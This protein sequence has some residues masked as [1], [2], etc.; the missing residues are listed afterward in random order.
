MGE[1]ANCLTPP[2]KP[3][4]PL[5]PRTPMASRLQSPTSFPLGSND[6]QLERAQAR[7]ARAASI[8][9]KP[10]S[11]AAVATAQE[12][13]P[14]SSDLL[15]HDQIMDLFH[16]CIKLASENK[17]NQKN[18]WDLGLIDHLSEIV[19]ARPE[20]DDETNFQKASCT[21]EAGVKIYSMRVD[22]VHSEAYKVLGGINRAGR[23][24][25]KET[26]E[27]CNHVDTAQGEGL[28]K[29]DLER[30]MSPVSTLESS[31]DALNVKKFDV[32]FTVDPLYHQTSAQ[33][34]EGGAKG[35][36]LNNLG[37]YG[38]CRVLFDSLEAPDKSILTEAQLDKS[39]L[40][41]LSFVKE[42]IESMMIHMPVICDISPTL[43]D[44]LDQ[45]DEENRRPSD[46][47]FPGQMPVIE[48]NEIGDNQTG[49]DGNSLPDC[50][51]CNFDNDDHESVVDDM[52]SVMDPY[53]TSYQEASGDYMFEDPGIEEKSEKIA[54]FLS[55]GLG[56]SSKTNAWA[57]PDHWKYRKVKGLEPTPVSPGE[58]EIAAKKPKS[59]K[60]APDIDFTKSLDNEMPDIFAPPKNPKSLL[61]P[62]NRG[63]CNITLPEDCHYRPESLVKLFVL[64]DVM[65]LRRKGTKSS[66]ESR[67]DNTDFLPS[68]SWD[69]ESM[70]N[71]QLDDA[72]I[73]SDVEDPGSLLRKPRQ[74]NKIDI[75]YD[76]VSKQVDV[77]ALKDTLWNHIQESIQNSEVERR[78]ATVSLTH[79]MH[80]LPNNCP[81]ASAKDISPHLLFICLLHLANEH[82]LA[83]HDCPTLDE[84]DIHIPPSALA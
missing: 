47:A 30:K 51:P 61:L 29:K 41:D 59:R 63:P 53:P 54:D 75:Q 69:N 22:S 1:V 39:D 56:F 68:S 19:R 36:L 14:P 7:A 57:G 40:I 32:A 33:F 17:I 20:D 34:D 83:L 31:F 4:R 49:L 44:I 42:H 52:P 48:D 67:E 6:D 35:L 23:E 24:E 46:A 5:P 3:S 37:V 71:D 50:G 84:V 81:A 82:C 62:A 21:L 66:D 13:P 18:T 26:S 72:N 8:R 27:D 58:T 55:L 2:P 43:K 73:S 10:S 60:G 74:V 76:K 9:R 28:S 79:V 70:I 12:N 45:F 64:P 80:Y 78:E 16:N 38:G 11:A 77:H 65:C 15:H 25:E